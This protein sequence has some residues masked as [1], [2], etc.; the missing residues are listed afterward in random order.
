MIIYI[1]KAGIQNMTGLGKKFELAKKSNFFPFELFSSKLFGVP[2]EAVGLPK[3]QT[4]HFKAY[5]K[6]LRMNYLNMTNSYKKA[7]KNSS[8]LRF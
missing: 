3:W 4:T 2:K 7:H 6:W 5:S 8:E 1:L